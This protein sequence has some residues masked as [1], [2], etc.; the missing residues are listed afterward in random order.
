MKNPFRICLQMQTLRE[1]TR[2]NRDFRDSIALQVDLKAFI[3][4][5][6]YLRTDVASNMFCEISENQVM[7]VFP[8]SGTWPI[9][10]GNQTPPR[11][12]V[13]P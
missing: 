10:L 3:F 7:H 13:K 11:E 4:T 12:P 9:S 2:K 5:S 6:H 1:L 8:P